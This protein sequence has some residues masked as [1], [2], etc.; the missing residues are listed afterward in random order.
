MTKTQFSILMA[1]LGS[2]AIAA[3][4]LFPKY[5]QAL[6]YAGS[7]FAGI[8]IPRAGKDPSSE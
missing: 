6:A 2:I 4:Q 7:L 5:S 1:T 8:A 3:S